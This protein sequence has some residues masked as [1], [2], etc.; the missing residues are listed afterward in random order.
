MITGM[1]TVFEIILISNNT[2]QDW[3]F[4]AD[5]NPHVFKSINY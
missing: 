2:Y 1:Q 4:G 5:L 3:T